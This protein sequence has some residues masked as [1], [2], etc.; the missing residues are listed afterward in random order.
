[1]PRRASGH[2]KIKVRNESM[3]HDSE[4]KQNPDW[5]REAARRVRHVNGRREIFIVTHAHALPVSMG[6]PAGNEM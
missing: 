6:E 1:M 5:Q 3:Y 2:V 4:L